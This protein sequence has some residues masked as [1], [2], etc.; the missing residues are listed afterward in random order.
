MTGELGVES[1]RGKGSTFWFTVC[2]T[3]QSPPLLLS[4][5]PGMR[6]DGPPI[7]ARASQAQGLSPPVFRSHIL[8]VED[9]TVNQRL[10]TRLLEKLG[11]Q[12]SLASNGQEAVEAVTNGSYEA[13]LMD[14]QMPEMDGFEATKIIRAREKQT[15]SK[16]SP[17]SSVLSPQDSELRTP[18]SELFHIPIIALTANAM[19]G[20]RE[21]CLAAGMDDYLAKPL[22]PQEL[23]AILE[24]W[25]AKV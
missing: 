9:N 20:D 8:L 23:K 17:R 21:R 7:D 5:D 24:R 19:H 16:L 3:H 25:V 22:N 12:V 2:L 4:P 10:A 1:E 14:C 18:N 15:R 13:I 11:Y 6:K